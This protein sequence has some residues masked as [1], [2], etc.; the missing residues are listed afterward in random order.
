M[1]IPS[2]RDIRATYDKPAKIHKTE[3]ECAYC[4]SMRK[5]GGKTHVDEIIEKAE[6][7]CTNPKNHFSAWVGAEA[8]YLNHARL[9]PLGQIAELTRI[10]AKTGCDCRYGEEKDTRPNS[11]RTP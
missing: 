5:F 9:S 4:A 2:L 6:S 3:A 7:L 11:Q 1:T 10:H 8:D